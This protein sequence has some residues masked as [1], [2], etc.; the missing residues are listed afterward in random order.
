MSRCADSN[1]QAAAELD[2]IRGCWLL[3]L[4]FTSGHVRVNDSMQDV[5]VS[6]NTYIGVGGFG[7]FDGFEE[8]VEFVARG[9][10]FEL[11]ATDSALANTVVTE[12]YQCRPA[13]IYVAM[14]DENYQLIGAPEARWSGFMDTMSIQ[15]S[16]PEAKYTLSC[17]HRMRNAPKF[18]RWAD[19]DQQDRSAGDRFFIMLPMVAGFSTSWGGIK[20]GGIIRGDGYTGPR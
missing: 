3:D 15:I 18:S 5:I 11:G 19:A 17:E 14:L 9:M 12:Q 8:S 1:N 10:R 16:G 2:A 7:T 6:G 20:V 13:T 4:A